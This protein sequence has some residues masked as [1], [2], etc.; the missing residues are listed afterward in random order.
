MLHFPERA[1]KTKFS[2]KM[3][4]K[5]KILLSPL[6][7]LNMQPIYVYILLVIHLNYTCLINHQ[8]FILFFLVLFSVLHTQILNFLVKKLSKFN[9]NNHRISITKLGIKKALP[10]QCTIN[11]ENV[12]TRHYMILFSGQ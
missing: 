8:D 9:K 10:H 6:Q 5:T 11:K 7:N 2:Y 1:N 4:C 12:K 3:T